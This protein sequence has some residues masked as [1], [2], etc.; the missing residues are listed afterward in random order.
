[1]A[2]GAGFDGV[3]SGGSI[4]IAEASRAK[5]EIGFLLDTGVATQA[6]NYTRA[7]NSSAFMGAAYTLTTHQPS[8]NTSNTRYA[9]GITSQ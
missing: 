6:I 3:Y 7:D 8:Y 4:S 2:I 9:Q 1:M 5:N